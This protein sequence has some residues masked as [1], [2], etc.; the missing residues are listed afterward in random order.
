MEEQIIVDAQSPVRPF[1]HFWEHMF[2]S[3][4]ASVTLCEDWRKDLRALREIVDVKYVRFHGIFEHQVGIYGGQD[5]DGNL[6]LNFTRIDL[7]YDGLLEIGVAPFVE[8][9]FMPEEMAMKPTAHPFWYHPIVAPPRD[10]RQW[11]QLLFQFAHHLVERYG[12]EE[13]ADWYFEVWNEPNIDFWTGEP[14]EETYYDL[15]D[16]AA[17]ALK[18]V[19]S[20]LRVGGPATAQA[21]WV[22]RFLR[23][24]AEK[25]VPVDFVSTHIYPNDTAM[26]VFGREENIPQSDMVALAVRKV[27]DQVK[28]SA[29]PQLPIIWSEYNAG[30]DGAQLDLPYVGAWLANNIRLCAGWTSEMSYW[31]FTDAFFEE[32]GVLKSVFTSGFGLIATGRIPKASFNA[33]KILHYLGDLQLALDSSSA[34]LT[35]RSSDDGLVLALWNYAPPRESG[36]SKAVQIQLRGFQ[37]SSERARIFLVDDDHGSPLKSWVAMGRP[38]FPSREQQAA[39]RDV[40]QLPP[41]LIAKLVDGRLSVLLQPSALAVIE[42][43]KA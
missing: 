25:G 7:I 24:C 27:Y 29:F 34:L 37:K 21:A 11:Y 13:V 17:S 36:Q 38:D 14:K 19:N 4:H 5:S 31:T 8:L 32:G 6:V 1:P 22:D 9:S 2:G 10:P 15:Y 41:P 12:I 35:R 20:R 43:V 23:H 18:D 3:C 28:A 26:N 33:F 42:F 39:L 40:A 16:V 30:F